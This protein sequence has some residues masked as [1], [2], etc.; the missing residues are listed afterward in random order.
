MTNF[1]K[2]TRHVLN[3]FGL[4]LVP[5]RG[6]EPAPTTPLEHPFDANYRHGDVAFEV[7]LTKCMYPYHFS[8][9]PAGWHPFVQVLRQY[10]ADPDLKYEDSILHAYYQKY[11]PKNVLEA[12]FVTLDMRA[13]F[14]DS[15]LASLNIPPFAPFFPWDP[16]RPQTFA[17]K[18]LEPSQGNQGYG[19]VSD[20]KGNLEFQRLV[21]TY[22][23]IETHG[24]QPGSGHD[25]DIRGYFLKSNDDYRFVVRQGLHRA[26]VLAV[27]S[28]EIGSAETRP[29]ATENYEQVRVRFY[30]PYPRT[31][32]LHDLS[33]WPQVREGT[34]SAQLAERVFKLFF[35][36]D[37]RA[38]A[39][40]LG[41][42]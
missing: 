16:H 22:T 36:D 41:L 11:R 31:I 9:H 33:N 2:S 42:L 21:E 13:P 15:E 8:Y 7:P 6:S 19:P 35:E 18:G 10:R 37:G 26:A 28:D 24:F 29:A 25:G 32:F 27:M 5:K 14:A 3:R 20:A 34:M 23:S 1:R 4:E 12:F 30:A 39:E 17:E 40:Q 38:K